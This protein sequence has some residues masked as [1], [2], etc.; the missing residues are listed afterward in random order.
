M[1]QQKTNKH[2]QP[3]RNKKTITVM[4]VGWGE[5]HPSFLGGF[6]D[7]SKYKQ[8]G[9]MDI[10]CKE[11]SVHMALTAC[12]DCHMTSIAELWSWKRTVI[13]NRRHILDAKD[14]NRPIL[15]FSRKYSFKGNPQCVQFCPFQFLLIQHPTRCIESKPE[16]LEHVSSFTRHR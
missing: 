5:Y 6:W 3:N 13:K 2:K 9:V 1:A 7:W 10:Y 12:P 16:P 4:G 15:L 11:N 8:E 14:Y